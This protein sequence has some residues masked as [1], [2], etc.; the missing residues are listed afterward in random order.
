MKLK[1]VMD[2]SES[3]YI[4]GHTGLV[5]DALVD[6]LTSAGYSNLIL[7]THSEMNLLDEEK[8][9]LFFLKNKPDYVYLSAAKVGGIHANI[10]QPADFI[11]DNLKIQLNIIQNAFKHGVKKLIFLG[12]CC[13]YPKQC[14]QP[15][16]ESSLFT[17]LLEPSNKSYSIAKLVGLQMCQALNKQ[18]NTSFITVIPSN[19]YGPKDNYNPSRGHVIPSLL[20]RFIR[21]IHFG[22]KS[23]TVWGTGRIKREFIHS[24]DIA[25]AL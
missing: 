9:S 14:P 5:G 13:M 21:A 10:N 15:M 20:R 3:I 4:A 6:K 24:E 11:F 2:K 8:V 23:V 16:K 18:H 25:D 7:K 19:I 1:T 12:S 17:G 22:E